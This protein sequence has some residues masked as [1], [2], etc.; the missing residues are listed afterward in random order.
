MKRIIIILL[1]SLFFVNSYS[2]LEDDL[3]FYSTLTNNVSDSINNNDLT[4][5]GVT[6]SEEG[7]YFGGNDYLVF[8]SAFA[9]IFTNSFTISTNI[10]YSSFESNSLTGCQLYF[11]EDSSHTHQCIENRN[12]NGFGYYTYSADGRGGVYKNGEPSANIWYNETLTYNENTR[13]FT[14]YV[15]GVQKWTSTGSSG[16]GNVNTMRFGAMAWSGLDNYLN[17]YVRNMAIFDKTLNSTEVYNLNLNG[18]FN[19]E[20]GLLSTNIQDFYNSSNVSIQVNSTIN[21]SINYSLD[22]SNNITLCS[23]CNQTNL[24]LDNL[25]EGEYNL[26]INGNEFSFTIDLTKPQINITNITVINSYQVNLSDLFSYSD[27]FGINE[28]VIYFNDNTSYFCNSLNKVFLENGNFTFE[29]IAL[30]NANNRQSVN[31]TLL[32]NPIQVFRFKDESNNYISNFTLGNINYEDR[33]EIPLYDLG[34]G[35]HTL[36]FDKSGFGQINITFNF[37]I[38]SGLNS[39]YNVEFSKIKISVY[40]GKTNALLTTPNSKIVLVGKGGTTK[41]TSAG[42]VEYIDTNL[43]GSYSMTVEA[44]GYDKEN[45]YFSFNNREVKDIKVYLLPEADSEQFIF[46]CQGPFSDNLVG[47]TIKSTKWNSNISQY[48]IY[49]MDTVDANG[50]A[51]LNLELGVYYTILCEYQNRL[52][53]ITS[54]TYSTIDKE[55]IIPIIVPLNNPNEEYNQIDLFKIKSNITPSISSSNSSQAFFRLTYNDI[56]ETA[57]KHCLKIYKVNGNQ[58]LGIN[59]NENTDCSTNPTGIIIKQFDLTNGSNYL[60]KYYSYLDEKPYLQDFRSLN[61]SISL[62]NDVFIYF[63]LLVLVIFGIFLGLSSNFMELGVIGVMVLFWI[64]YKI[65]WFLTG[66]FG[67]ELL[68][69]FNVL[70]LITIWG[71]NKIK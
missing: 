13:T 58:E 71:I 52:G 21:T 66:P 60:A 53:T 12:G 57:D 5:Y 24:T 31:S 15:N 28:C 64:F 46:Q 29:V 27:N 34:L 10:K 18:L 47:A 32:V 19:N 56:D 11:K 49:S 22:N 33:A 30:D 67:F 7:A 26:S 61:T 41:T 8:P 59:F 36:L 68:V 44:T 43:G 14:F 38:T 54:S 35:E 42:K 40:N 48:E 6:F 25:E 70:G 2:T 63:I 51:S 45:Y 39:D 37:T 62:E 20:Q 1:L 65:E 3:F 50:L 4:N 9:N 17:G 69:G 55:T 16:I 23:N